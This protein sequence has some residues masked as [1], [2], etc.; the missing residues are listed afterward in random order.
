MLFSEY[1]CHFF[2]APD[3]SNIASIITPKLVVILFTTLLAG[4]PPIRPVIDAD[5]TIP[6]NECIL[7]FKIKNVNIAISL[8]FY[9]FIYIHLCL[10]YSILFYFIDTFLFISIYLEYNLFN[11]VYS[12][13]DTP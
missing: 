6:K 3:T 5:I 8:C 11:L 12:K 7:V 1:L 4:I 9:K 13:K 10:S 2:A